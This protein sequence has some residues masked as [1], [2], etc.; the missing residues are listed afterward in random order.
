MG[1]EKVDDTFHFISSFLFPMGLRLLRIA[2]LVWTELCSM[3]NL[4]DAS[5]VKFVVGR[6]DS[7]L[8]TCLSIDECNVCPCQTRKS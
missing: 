6:V 1:E 5:L 4:A 2:T 3:A 7:L 8:S